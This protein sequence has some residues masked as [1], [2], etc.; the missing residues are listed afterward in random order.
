MKKISTE[1]SRRII[2]LIIFLF[3]I[4]I[5]FLNFYQII[6]TIS[7]R[8]YFSLGMLA[9][10]FYTKVQ[11]DKNKIYN[12]IY[13]MLLI[14]TFLLFGYIILNFSRIA[15][16]GGVLSNIDYGV[17]FFA[18]FLILIAG[19]FTSKS[20]L[21]LV[22][23]FFA[24]ALFGR[25]AP[26]AISH[27]GFS[28]NRLLSHLVWGSQGIFGVAIG[29]CASY[30]FVFIMFGEFLK[31]SGMSDFINDI[32]LA[33]IG[34]KP[35]GPAKVAVV[36]SALMGMINGS[37][38]ANVA[39]TGTITIPLMKDVGYEKEFAAAVEATASTGGQF[40][41]PIMGAVGFIM[42]EYLRISYSKVMIAAILPA[43]LYYFGVMVS[44]HL[45]AKR[46]GL[47]GVAK[48]NLPDVKEVIKSRGILSIPIF[49]LIGLIM[50]GFSPIFSSVIGILATI[51][52]SQFTKDHKMNLELIKKSLIDGTLATVNV[53]ISCLLI[54]VI[55]GIVS[56]TALGLNFG[57]L[58][59]S[60]SGMDS[61]LFAGF[62]VMTMSTILGMGVP[63][64]AAYVIVV[65]VAVP[66]LLK[67]GANPIAA[68]MFCLIYACLSNITPPV[69]ISS[70][71]AAGIAGANE[72]K[73]SIIA[74]KLGITG[75]LLPFFF[76]IN[77][78]L[79][80]GAVE[81]VDTFYLI[82]IILTS[83][84]GVFNIAASFEGILKN[85][86]SGLDRILL[87]AVGLLMIDP[88]LVTD[89][90]GIVVFILIFVKD[91]RRKEVI[92]A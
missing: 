79:L 25:Y 17:G 50:V 53:G 7:F 26:A 29:V 42:A 33:F 92:E 18:I 60:M 28:I 58:I 22:L 86:L 31:N 70:Y 24:Y 2:N 81:N 5:I 39:T 40:C 12:W 55:I 23:I 91:F 74:V 30:I 4:S 68:H 38:V 59:M 78:E 76:L 80:L 32:A 63:G 52:V 48:E 49:V 19:Y 83:T 35:G 88:N 13:L 77:P 47:K 67:I 11:K 34:H 51:V 54:G 89:I 43:F 90:L 46:L 14:A 65:S 61:L 1:K 6:E 16:S 9:L 41:P 72:T 85:R 20:L 21:I 36:A 64:V 37:A 73:T 75:F 3:S 66:V 10:V 15:L 84:F 8:S 71:V 44:V 87:F 57:N 82:R 62:L 27:S 69:A 56:L 45:E